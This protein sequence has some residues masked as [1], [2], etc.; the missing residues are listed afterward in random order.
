MPD[1]RRS[2]LLSWGLFPLVV[3]TAVLVAVILGA[4][5]GRQ[6]IETASTTGHWGGLLAFALLCGLISFAVV[7][8]SK[9]LIPVREWLQRRYMRQWWEARAESLLVSREHSWT[10]LMEAMNRETVLPGLRGPDSSEDATNSVTGPYRAS[11]DSVFGLPIQ[12][13]SAQISNAIDLAL[14]EPKR[15]QQLYYILTRSPREARELRDTLA[16]ISLRAPSLSSLITRYLEREISPAR[17]VAELRN[18]SANETLEENDSTIV[19]PIRVLFGKVFDLLEMPFSPEDSRYFRASQ[20]AR[21]ALDALQIF[22]GGRWRRSVQAS[23][24]LI[25]TLAAV[26]IQLTQPSSESRWLFILSAALISGPL[27][28][29]I[30]DITAVIERWRR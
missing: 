24:V 25:A 12:L 5:F 2:R 14:I 20:R 30:R 3:A 28:W 7:E 15:Y 16:A 6:R 21:S 4:V 23:A 26:L 1:M 22:V 18:Y 9:R 19:N 10:Q 13:L 11:D 17:L 27:A 8:M 29:I